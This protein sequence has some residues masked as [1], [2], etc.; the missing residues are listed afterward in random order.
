MKVGDLVKLHDTGW[1][2]GGEVGIIVNSFPISQTVKQKEKS[3]KPFAFKVL[4][5]RGK[6]ISKLRDQMEVLNESR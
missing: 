1:R 4:L 2:Y 6:V 3:Y 5:S